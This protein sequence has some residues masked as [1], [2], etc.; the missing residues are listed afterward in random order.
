MQIQISEK[1]T[2]S[3][4]VKEKNAIPLWFCFPSTYSIGM[5]GLGYLALFRK[6]DE[7]KDVNPERIFTDTEKTRLSPREIELMGFSFTFELDFMGIFKLLEKYNIPLRSSERNENHPLIFGGGP[8][9]TANPEPFTEFFDFITIGDGEEIHDD[10]INCYKQIRSIKNREEKLIQLSKIDG[11]YVPSLYDVD[12][13]E[14]LT[15]KSFKPKSTEIPDT[16]N[17]RCTKNIVPTYTPILTSKSVFPDN[18]LIEVARGCPRMCNF[19]LASFHNLPARYPEYQKITETIDL[20]LQNSDKIGLLG[21]SIS[22][23]PDF[24]KICEYILNKRKEK[25]FEI[26]V[27]SLRADTISDITCKTLVECG[28]KQ[29][30]IAIE[31]GSDRLR[32]FIN[33][34]LNKETITETVKKA[35]QCDLTGLKIYGMIGLPTENQNDLEEFIELFEILKKETKG[36][37]LTL[38]ISSF[39]PKANTPFQWDKREDTKILQERSDYLKKELSKIKVQFKPTSI[40]WDYVQA[41]LSRADRR[42]APVLEKVYELGNSL[43][44]WERSYK[45]VKSKSDI[46]IPELEWYALRERNYNE[47][48]PW[49]FINTGINPDFLKSMRDKSYQNLF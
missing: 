4:A 47:R 9:L 37:A 28:Q 26:S 20:G 39:V 49:E 46:L 6:L 10:L 8:V 13:N 30:T 42:I 11:L 33:K 1:F 31:A 17:K 22:E 2:Y 38:S 3:P 40:K 34:N 36:F 41:I 35:N 18:F 7:N 45:E 27:S 48:L 24:D 32:K 19:C 43:G 44:T 5:S 25:E 29:S 12:Y 16:I 21:A 15:I 14:D 23:H